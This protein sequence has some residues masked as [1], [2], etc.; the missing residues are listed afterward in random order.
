MA[1]QLAETETQLKTVLTKAISDSEFQMKR[2]VSQN[3]AKNSLDMRRP[4]IMASELGHLERKGSVDTPIKAKVE[5]K[6]AEKEEANV[7]KEE[8]NAGDV[9]MNAIEE[10]G[11]VKESERAENLEQEIEDAIEE[12]SAS[13]VFLEYDYDTRKKLGLVVAKEIAT[14][15]SCFQPEFSSISVEVAKTVTKESRGVNCERL[16][17]LEI[18]SAEGVSLFKNETVAEETQTTSSVSKITAGIEEFSIRYKKSKTDAAVIAKP[19]ENE[20]SSNIASVSLLVEISRTDQCADATPELISVFTSTERISLIATKVEDIN[21]IKHEV[22]RILPSIDIKVSEASF[23]SRK[24]KNEIGTEFDP[25]SLSIM[26]DIEEFS[27]VKIIKRTNAEADATIKCSSIATECEDISNVIDLGIYENDIIIK[28][29]RADKESSTENV[30]LQ[31]CSEVEVSIVN[32]IERSDANTNADKVILE[33][34]VLPLLNLELVSKKIIEVEGRVGEVSIINEV[35]RTVIATESEEPA[36]Q[37]SSS[38]TTISIARGV[39]KLNEILVEVFTINIPKEPKPEPHLFHQGSKKLTSKTD[40]GAISVYST[41][42]NITLSFSQFEIIS[43][44]MNRV[45]K[46]KHDFA[47]LVNR[48]RDSCSITTSDHSFVLRSNYDINNVIEQLNI[49]HEEEELK[50]EEQSTCEDPIKRPSTHSTHTINIDPL[51]NFFF[52]VLAV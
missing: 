51:K 20:I 10:V 13:N 22:K 37:I 19:I 40:I 11:A 44:T 16:I 48:E 30:V 49:T 7:E 41:S 5:K 26:N 36:M 45:I 35:Q 31:V 46:E 52:L 43:K 15:T 9:Q 29:E 18:Y 25:P 14:Q 12:K 23:E 42:K 32:T 4:S 47:V 38:L 28:K 2:I 50:S 33:L 17:T 39:R 6:D 1:K 8:V 21:Y 3:L 34:Q 24:E 27:I